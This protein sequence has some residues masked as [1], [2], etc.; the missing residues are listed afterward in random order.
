MIELELLGSHGDGS[1]LVFTDTDG[2]RYLVAITDALK[3]AIRREELQVEL[4]GLSQSELNPREIQQLL[5][6]GMEPAELA[7]AYDLEITRVNRFLAPILAER[8]FIISAALAAPVGVE[9]DAPK[10]EDVVIDR[11]ATRAVD[12]SSLIWSASRKPQQD[13][14]LHL[15]FVQA[16]RSMQATWE[17]ESNGRLIRAVDEQARWLTETL[18]TSAERDSHLGVVSSPLFHAPG[19]PENIADV[20]KLLDELAAQRGKRSDESGLA[21]PAPIVPPVPDLQVSE[22]GGEVSS[23]NTEVSAATELLVVPT[24]EVEVEAAPTISEDAVLL[25]E[26]PTLVSDDE[27]LSL[28][29]LTSLPEEPVEKPKKPAAKRRSVP[30]WDEIIFGAKGD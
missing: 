20:E 21:A 10:L 11:L 19:E 26:S 18:T 28:P 6:A 3:A 14:Q 29:G 13:W 2:Q 16:A 8:T 27:V 5:R 1:Q 23:V 15:T 25:K 7:S 12:P 4:G 30:T 22:G 24:P 17:I 9:K